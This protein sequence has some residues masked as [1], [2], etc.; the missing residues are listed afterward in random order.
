[1]TTRVHMD[2]VMLC[3]L[4]STPCL[5]LHTKPKP[6][7]VKTCQSRAARKR[8]KERERERE[9]E[10]EKE[11]EREKRERVKASALNLEF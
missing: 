8:K 3:M 5:L 9:R 10:R 4:Y 11:K 6:V 2:Q 1:M 7:I